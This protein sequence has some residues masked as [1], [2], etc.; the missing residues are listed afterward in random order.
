MSESA[1]QQREQARPGGETVPQ[2]G[3]QIRQLRVE[4]GKGIVERGPGQ[5]G[6]R[7]L[8]VVAD[9]DDPRRQPEQERAGDVGLAGLIDDDDVEL[10][11]SWRQRFGH[12]A[13][14]HDPRRDGTGGLGHRRP[15]RRPKSI[16][17]LARSL[18]EIDHVVAVG[19]QCLDLGHAGSLHRCTPG[20]CGGELGGDLSQIHLDAVEFVLAPRLRL[21]ITVFEYPRVR[22][23]PRPGRRQVTT[24]L[25]PHRIIGGRHELCIQVGGL[26][27]QS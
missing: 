7:T 9:D 4:F 12:L 2:I 23:P 21:R 27:A 1:A 26:G 5:T 11:R 20:T 16:G 15:R 6:G 17:M 8:S 13:D 24:A 18:A 10:V 22:P 14:R 25:V 3:R 19:L